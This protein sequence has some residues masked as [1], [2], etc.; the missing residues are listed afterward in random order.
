MLYQ[1]PILR[2]DYSDPDMIRVGEDYY[3]VSSSFTYLPGI[4]VLHSRDLVHWRLINYAARSLPFERYNAPAHKCGTWAPSIRYHNGTYYVYICLPDE[5]LLAFTASDPA[6]AWQP[7]YVKDVTGWIDPCPFWDEDG[8]AY[9]LH[10]FAASRAGIK[11]ILYLHRMS[12]DG[13]HILDNGQMVF[14]GK[15]ENE[16]TEGPKMYK[17]DGLYYIL[18]PAGGVAHGW[19]LA[20]RSASPYG[21]YE[22]KRVL[23]QGSTPVNGPHQ[24]GWVDTPFGEDWFIHFQDVGVYGRI[25]HLQPV[26]WADGWPV[27]GSG[28][29]PVMACEAPRASEQTEPMIPTSDE[30]QG[31]LSLAWQWQANPR[32]AWYAFTPAGLRLF[33]AQAPSLFM[34]GQVL[35]QLMQSFR[36]SMEVRLTLHS[37]SDTDC[38]GIAVM[39]YQ[40]HYLA[41]CPG[42]IRLMRGLAKERSRFVPTDV[43]EAELES[44]PYANDIAYFR[45]EVSDG[46]VCFFFRKDGKAWQPLGGEVPLSCGGWTGARPGIFAM[47]K[48]ASDGYADFAYC[49]YIN[50]LSNNAY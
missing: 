40:Y 39:G 31:K 19:Q 16:T 13:L 44:R 9:L 47:S 1:N 10:A 48:E 43:R 24:G 38:A 35:S 15:L 27:I 45:L 29:K 11:S 28:G 25:P 5:G 41:L 8:S 36:F 33:A 7:H 21:P 6:D 23:E 30:F 50:L 26:H 34:A 17:R 3:M 42:E 14:D 37:S 12:P 46:S 20:M 49:R 22:V 2:G 4:P 32:Q 18:A